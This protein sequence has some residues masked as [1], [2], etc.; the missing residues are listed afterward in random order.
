MPLPPPPDVPTKTL[1]RVELWDEVECN[2]GTRQSFVRLADMISATEHLE[3]QGDEYVEID[4]AGTVDISAFSVD[5]VLRLVFDDDTWTEYRL[6]QI[7]KRR[8]GE[9][10]LHSIRADGIK[11]DLARNCELLHFTQANGVV[12]M[13]HELLGI[14]AEEMLDAII[15]AGGLPAYITKGTIEGGQEYDIVWDWETHLAAIEEIATVT[16][17]EFQL[18]RNGV[19]DYKIDLLEQINSGADIPEARV[20]RNILSLSVDED[21]SAMATLIY[22]KG[23]G[24]QG[25]S[26]T[27]GDARFWAKSTGGD[28]SATYDLWPFNG[29]QASLNYWV[30]NEDDQFNGYYLEY[31]K[32][33]IVQITDQ[34][35]T[36]GKTIQVTLASSI[37]IDEEVVRI[38]EGAALDQGNI[39]IAAIPLPSAQATYGTKPMILERNDI[40]GVTNLWGACFPSGIGTGFVNHSFAYTASFVD[41]PDAHVHYGTRSIK[42]EGDTGAR[43][44]VSLAADTNLGVSQVR[45]DLLLNNPHLTWQAWLFVEVGQVGMYLTFENAQPYEDGTPFDRWPLL[46]SVNEQGELTEYAKTDWIRV[47][48]ATETYPSN[49][50]HLVINPSEVDFIYH[51]PTGGWKQGDISL[52]FTPLV[53]GT[54]FYLNAMQMVNQVYPADKIVG[55]SSSMHLWDAAV[56]AFGRTSAYYPDDDTVAAPK[57]S[58]DVDMLDLYRLAYTTYPYDMLE[59]GVTLRITDSDLDITATRRVFS[60]NRD[61]L[62]EAVTGIELV[63]EDVA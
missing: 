50:F 30:C 13:H 42:L 25:A 5:D 43:Y 53:D 28:P 22:P 24:P 10:L 31:K 1:V 27:M 39:E 3:L 4:M 9:E 62:E 54:V 47:D 60:V 36:D 21:Y 52:N 33:Q 14:D 35:L 23:E 38:V 2:S 59:P 56:R 61:L 18:R 32:G 55:G 16:G 41:A 44:E 19:T 15:G 48:T 40:P 6:Q 29:G 26:P 12:L 34:T 57:V 17:L 45:N 46:E 7:T 63:E 49:W 37:S 11:F 8:Q 58:L 20:G 51:E